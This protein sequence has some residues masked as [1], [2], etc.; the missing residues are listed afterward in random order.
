MCSRYLS[1]VYSTESDKIDAGQNLG[2][3]STQTMSQPVRI[4][5][6][7]SKSSRCKG[8]VDATLSMAWPRGS[9][10]HAVKK[11]FVRLRR[12]TAKNIAIKSSKNGVKIA[13]LITRLL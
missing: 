8:F 4:F 6:Q 12:R 11:D 3:H 10:E 9:A 2:K 1:S 5:L 7:R 13:P